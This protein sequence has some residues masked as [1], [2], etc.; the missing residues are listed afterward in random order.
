MNSIT[1]DAK[2]FLKELIQTPSFSREEYDTMQVI[3]KWLQKYDVSFESRENNIWA[4]NKFYDDDLPTILLN[5]HHDTVKPSSDYT[6]NPF[7][8]EEKDGKIW[9]V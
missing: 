2:L 3:K 5:S 4:K 7:S 6:I 9:E 8:G 1:A